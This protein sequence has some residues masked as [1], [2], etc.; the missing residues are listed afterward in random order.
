MDRAVLAHLGAC[1]YLTSRRFAAVLQVL[2]RKSHG[3]E[4]IKDR[5]GPDSSASLHDDVRMQARTWPN[6]DLRADLAP[7]ADRHP[8]AEHCLRRNQGGRVDFGLAWP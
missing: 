3:A 2:R 4:R 6:D 8:R 5:V 7:G 1:A